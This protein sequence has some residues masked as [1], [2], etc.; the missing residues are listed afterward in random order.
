MNHACKEALLYANLMLIMT[1]K[2]SFPLV[3]KVKK[4]YPTVLL[5]TVKRTGKKCR[6]SRLTKHLN[7]NINYIE[8]LFRFL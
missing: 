6:L 8:P 7:F 5:E 4:K 2:I 1:I 3:K